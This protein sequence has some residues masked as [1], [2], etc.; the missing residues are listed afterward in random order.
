MNVAEEESRNVQMLGLI[1]KAIQIP[2]PENLKGINTIPENS[3]RGARQ[4]NLAF[5]RIYY[6]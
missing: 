4:L 1:I 2:T 3:L 5:S 6:P